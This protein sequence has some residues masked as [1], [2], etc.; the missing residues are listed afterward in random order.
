MQILAVSDEVVG[1]LY[2]Q[3]VQDRFRDV[4]LIL[5]CG[6]L[7]SGYL[8]YL[9]TELNV[10][11]LYVPG[12]HDPDDMAVPGGESIDGRIVERGGLR[13][14]GLGGC[15]RYKPEGRHQYTENEM[16]LRTAALLP[17]VLLARTL[18][19]RGLDVLVTHAPPRGVH[20]GPDRVHQGFV[21]LRTFVHWA[22]P[23]VMVHGH[24]HIHANVEESETILKGTRVVNV[25]PYRRLEILA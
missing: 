20:E 1:F 25:F 16:G 10:P 4:D 14:A 13:F 12:N 19:G 2:S 3:A 24:S 23:H 5:G 22:R 18:R 17:T 8:E 21:A 11:L 6:D 9:V 15:L 7:P